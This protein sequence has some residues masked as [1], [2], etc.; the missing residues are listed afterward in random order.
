M[1]SGEPGLT[2]LEARL[3]GI[4]HVLRDRRLKVPKYQRAYAWG[5]EQIET[6]WGDLRS[7]M[8]TEKPS[9]FLGTIVLS[10]ETG[11]RVSTIIDGQQRLASVAILLAA[12]RDEFKDAGEGARAQALQDQFLIYRDLKQA[13]EIARLQMSSSDAEFYF[14]WIVASRP[15]SEPVGPSPRRIQQAYELLRARVH[16]EALSAR[17]NWQDRLIRWVEFLEYEVR[18]IVVDVFSVADAFLLF[19]TLNDRGLTLTVADLLKNYLYGLATL[20]LGG[21][22]AAWERSRATLESH[23]EQLFLDFLRQYWSSW[24]GAVRERDLYRSFRSGVRS[25]PQALELSESLA[26]AS[27]DYLALATGDASLWPEG[28]ITQ[29]E[30]DTLQLLRV[31]QNRPLLLAAMD[32]FSPKELGRLARA[33]VSWLVRALLVGGIGGGTSEVYF[34]R[35]AVGIREKRIETT[36]GVLDI[37]GVVVPTDEQ[38]RGVARNMAAPRIELVKYLLT[39]YERYLRCEI[40]PAIVSREELA[41]LSVERVLPKNADGDWPAFGES[42]IANWSKRLGNFTLMAA[43]EQR[44]RGVREW[45]VV[46]SAMQGSRLKISSPFVGL[47]AWSPEAIDAAQSAFAD[48]A[49]KIWPR[50]P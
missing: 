41:Q 7:A 31:S 50:D 4:A 9:Y 15:G 44:R 18:T 1:S 16:E 29:A 22:E 25:G 5:K 23:D 27:T 36:E 11:P 34:S 43:A 2:Q 20:E 33:T 37:V 6:F 21:V 49:P 3:D 12:I 38:F 13:D 32:H 48:A 46:K 19:E 39:A 30:A 45:A 10:S 42:D 24:Y 47:D 14:S 26:D 35:A 17:S 28:S 40:R 8:L